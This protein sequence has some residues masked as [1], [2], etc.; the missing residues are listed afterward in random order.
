L[1]AEALPFDGAKSPPV[2]A[3]HQY[4]LSAAAKK[5]EIPFISKL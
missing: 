3:D 1:K 4:T 2:T 5:L